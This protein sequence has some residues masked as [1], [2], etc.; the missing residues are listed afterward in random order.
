MERPTMKILANFSLTVLMMIFV[1]L[2]V[3]Q[4]PS[5]YTD[6][7]QLNDVLLGY[8]S[9]IFAL[10]LGGMLIPHTAKD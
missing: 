10:W 7:K 8:I 5:I 2:G 1:A 9:A 4:L 3:Y 6:P